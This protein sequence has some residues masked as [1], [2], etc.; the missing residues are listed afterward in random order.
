MHKLK[1]LTSNKKK[2][3]SNVKALL[4]TSS[5]Y[6]QHRGQ[7]NKDMKVNNKGLHISTPS[8]N[9]TSYLIRINC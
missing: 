3:I 9:T 5:R 6:P 1:Q 2:H 7:R 4:A 8:I